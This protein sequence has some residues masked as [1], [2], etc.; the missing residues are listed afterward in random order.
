[1]PAGNATSGIASGTLPIRAQRRISPPAG[2]RPTRPLATTYSVESRSAGRRSA[3]KCRCRRADRLTEICQ[4]GARRRR[5]F[6]S[7]QPGRG[8]KTGDED[9]DEQ[10]H[11]KAEA[12]FDECARRLAPKID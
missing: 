12:F 10:K 5:L 7:E 8:V 6:V 4:A 9:R 11:E 2:D 1:M 3:P